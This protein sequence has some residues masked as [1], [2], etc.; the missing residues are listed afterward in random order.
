MIYLGGNIYTTDRIMHQG[1]YEA[2]F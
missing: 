2:D 1:G